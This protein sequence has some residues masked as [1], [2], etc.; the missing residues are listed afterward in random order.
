[1]EFIRIFI[2]GSTKHAAMCHIQVDTL[3]TQVK[4]RCAL[5]GGSHLLELYSVCEDSAY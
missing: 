2:L 5:M 3:G 1:M 4:D